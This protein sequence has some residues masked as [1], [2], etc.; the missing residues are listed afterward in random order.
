MF[1]HVRASRIELDDGLSLDSGLGMSSQPSS[2]MTPKHLAS[3]EYMMKGL[4]P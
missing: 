4:S 1:H 2:P 3:F